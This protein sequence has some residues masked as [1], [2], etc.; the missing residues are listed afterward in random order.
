MR[1]VIQRVGRAS[2]RVGEQ[3]T[4]AIELG[5]LVLLGVGP[6]DAPEQADWL[7]RKIANLR[8]FR[9]EAD[10]MNLSLLDVQGEALVVSQFTLYGDCRRGRRPSFVKAAPPE[11]AEPLYE[12]F[13]ARLRSQGV[14]RV[15]QGRF[16]ADMKVELLNDGPVTLILDSP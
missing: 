10:R 12:E 13:C 4:G 7:A 11:R 16:A 2:V 15:A 9:D 6:E 1:A 5:L 8:I 3:T 14:R